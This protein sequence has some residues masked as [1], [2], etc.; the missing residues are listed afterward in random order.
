MKILLSSYVFS[1]SVGGIETVSALVAPEFVK[2]GHEV[3]LI[4]HTRREDHREWPFQV[5]RRPGARRL[6]E[7]VRWCDVYFQNNISLTYAWPLLFIHKPW[8]IAHHTWLGRFQ[9]DRDWKGQLKRLLLKYGTNA[10][11]SRAVARDIPVPSTIVGNP[12][13]KNVFKARPEISRVR[14]LVYLGRLVPDKGVNILIEALV[15]LKERGLT[16]HLTIIGSGPEETRLRQLAQDQQVDDQINFTGSKC[17][18]EIALLL[19]AHKILVVPSQWPEPFGI[20]VLEAMASGCVIVASEAGGLPEVVGR[21]GITYPLGDRAALVD[22]LALLLTDRELRN[23]YRRDADK[24]L[25]QFDPATVASRYLDVFA[26]AVSPLPIT[27]R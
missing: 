21:C 5:V 17:P 19:N 4:T 18:E 20:V 11:I 23:R 8:V 10:T 15:P 13:S 1:P 7:L 14:E 6:M 25:L 22:S 27:C 26:R 3:I 24:Q 16:P 9:G 12:Y 2:A